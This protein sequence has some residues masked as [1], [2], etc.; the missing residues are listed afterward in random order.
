MKKLLLIVMIGCLLGFPV[1]SQE[2]FVVYQLHVFNDPQE[3]LL[4]TAHQD[5]PFLLL[6]AINFQEDESGFKKWDELTQV[7][8]QKIKKDVG[9]VRM[10]S[11]LF[12]TTHQLMLKEY[13]KHAYFSKTLT[14]G[15]YD[16][17]TGT[18]LFALLLDR[19]Q[20][21]YW[22]VETQEHVYIKGE[23]GGRSFILES[24]FP[25]KGLITGKR[26][27]KN[28]E[29]QF[30]PN[31]NSSNLNNSPIGIGKVSELPASGM[32]LNYI[33]LREL[34]GLQYYNDAIRKFYEKKYKDAY[35]QLIKAAYLYPSSRINDL[36]SKMEILLGIISVDTQMQQVSLQE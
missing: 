26:E 15:L 11:E 33:G 13:A 4:L 31:G 22:I 14:D 18:G 12:F 20:I 23:I 35:I 9:N 10:L 34:A 25:D 3:K 2:N 8:D 27:I 29:S 32:D 19:Y 5:E 30:F 7:L 28:F 16:C 6:Q 36:K 17:V 1:K 21:P 24:T